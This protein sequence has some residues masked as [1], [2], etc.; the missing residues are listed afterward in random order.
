M[1]IFN[2][3]KKS[4][5]ITLIFILSFSTGSF[6]KHFTVPKVIIYCRLS[7]DGTMHISESRTYSFSGSF[8]YAYRTFPNDERVSFENFSVWEDS[9]QYILSDTRE[10]GTFMIIRRNSGKE[11]RWFYRAEN[12]AKTFKINYE[13]K[14]GVKRYS[15]SAVLYYQFISDTWDKKTGEVTVVIEPPEQ[16]PAEQVALWL[17][18][19][20][21]AQS[22]INSNGVIVGTCSNLPAYTYLEFRVIYPPDIFKDAA[23]IEKNVKDSIF[24]EEA[25]WADQANKK[26]IENR[27]RLEKQAQRTKN[28]TMLMVFVSL[29]IIAFWHNQHTK[30]GKKPRIPV[31][32]EIE[33]Q[34]PEGIT[35]ALAS[36]LLY[37]RQVYASAVPATM[38][39]LAG[40][41]ILKLEEMP[42]ERGFFKKLSVK[43]FEWILDR[44][45]Y[46]KLKPDMEDYEKTLIEF[47]FTDLAKDRDRLSTK[48]ISKSRSK[49]MKFFRDWTKLVKKHGQEK[50]WFD[51]KSIR[52]AYRS[53][54]G[55]GILFL[56]II[57]AAI[58]C[59]ICALV[60]TFSSITVF[61]LSLL[62]MHRTHEGEI[63]FRKLKGLKKYLMKYHFKS[64]SVDTLN[65]NIENYVVY[66][67][68]FGLGKKHYTE[69]IN[70][71]SPDNFHRA[72]PWYIYGAHSRPS[73]LASSFSQMITTTTSVMSSA[74]GTGGGASG[75]GGGGV[76][77]GG[78]GAG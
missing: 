18:G 3:L 75:G 23:I 68:I 54:I 29:L 42:E 14:N 28:G 12:Q 20:L 22:K 65:Q 64:K 27:I 5:V 67:A 19:P 10:P 69:L 16:I 4:S 59:N 49:F 9:L 43:N 32:P 53:M 57:P 58:Y 48:T 66:G 24:K 36:Y 25:D 41:G 45:K 44:E 76:S 17:H 39:D 72:V 33:S 1:K 56:F 7:S 13:V 38:F 8:S 61:I 71:V 34:L 74:T 46:E 15:D 55:S 60:I 40:R 2:I 50:N 51:K 47:L 26:R 35:P 11:V 6:A 52:A 70:A 62:I 78:G 77:A 37:S 31:Q 73:E 21:H 63:I 30:Y